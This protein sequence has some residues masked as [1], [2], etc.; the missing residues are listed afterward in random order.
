MAIDCLASYLYWLDKDKETPPPRS[1]I[2]DI[3]P[4]KLAEELEINYSEYFVNIVTVDVAEY[5]KLHF[6]KTVRKNLT[7]PAWL[8]DA[9]VSRGV[10]FSKTL[11]DALVKQLNL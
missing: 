11:K 6:E 5:A 7:I 9:A 4:E 2:K 1:D 8:N 10:N 3:S